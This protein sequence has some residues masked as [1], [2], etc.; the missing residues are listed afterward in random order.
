[1]TVPINF[2]SKHF[3]TR[4]SDLGAYSETVSL[5]RMYMYSGMTCTDM[6]YRYPM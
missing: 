4:E 2:R 1:M 5:L 3:E 6:H